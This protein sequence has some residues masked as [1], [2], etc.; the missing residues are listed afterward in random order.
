MERFVLW[1]HQ[2]IVFLS[3]Y[4]L[5]APPQRALRALVRS[6]F[7]RSLVHTSQ[8]ALLDT[9]IIS[10]RPCELRRAPSATSTAIPN[11]I[12]FIRAGAALICIASQCILFAFAFISLAGSKFIVSRFVVRLLRTARTQRGFSCRTVCRLNGKSGK[13][14]AQK[15]PTQC[16][17]PAKIQDDCAFDSRNTLAE[18]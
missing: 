4:F 14:S 11:H 16:C 9:F 2:L 10:H 1:F 13:M 17:V 15:W 18:E 6:P 12:V 7:L 8:N 5:C 3:V